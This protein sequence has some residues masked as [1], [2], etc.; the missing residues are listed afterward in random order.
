MRDDLI[1]MGHARAI[2]TVESEKDQLLIL[3]K[4]LIRK[5]SVRQVEEMVRNLISG[6]KPGTPPSETSLPP[7]FSQAK[8]LLNSA[9][10]SDVDVKLNRKGAGSIIISFK[11]SED[12]DRIVSKLES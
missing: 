5:L 11:S 9:L 3:Q 2:I 7:K 4:I 10:Q 1:T 8:E 12:F 6:N